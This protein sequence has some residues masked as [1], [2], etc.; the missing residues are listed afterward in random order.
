[1]VLAQLGAADRTLTHL[2][3]LV[4]VPFSS[5][6]LQGPHRAVRQSAAATRWK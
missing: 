6:D 3:K 5:K 4:A 1:L 2:N